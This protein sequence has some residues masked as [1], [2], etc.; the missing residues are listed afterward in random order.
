M[1]VRSEVAPILPSAEAARRIDSVCD[2]IEQQ[3]QES[4]S[5]DLGLFLEQVEEDLQAM[6][7]PQLLLLQWD[8]DGRIRESIDLQPYLDQF[9]S[10]TLLIQD[11]AVEH[12]T[13]F[14]QREQKFREA[15]NKLRAASWMAE[16]WEDSDYKILRR[17]GGGA[18]GSGVHSVEC[19]LASNLVAV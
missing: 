18:M 4:E 9:P 5:P 10:H 7:L 11:A 19:S 16:R 17:L 3:L 1:R 14:E 2:R 8:H 12:L 6:L 15:A 13:D